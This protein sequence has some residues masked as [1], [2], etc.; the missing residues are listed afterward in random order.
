MEKI[1]E[2]FENMNEYVYVADIDSYEM[3]YINNKT[4]KNIC[5]L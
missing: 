5:F 2:F 4:R 3:L 1:Y